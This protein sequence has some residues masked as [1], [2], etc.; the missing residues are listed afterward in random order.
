VV[1]WSMPLSVFLIPAAGAP[2]RR[3]AVLHIDRGNVQIVSG[4]ECDVNVL[5]PGRFE[6]V[7][8]M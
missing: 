5:V 8:V 2:S 1:K 3:H 4:L 6:L 7:D